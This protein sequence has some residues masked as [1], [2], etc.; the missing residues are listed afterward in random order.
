MFDVFDYEVD[1]R[2]MCMLLCFRICLAMLTAM[3]VFMMCFRMYLTEVWQQ[4][5][6]VYAVCFR[7]CLRF[8]A[9]RMCLCC[10]FQN[11]F[12]NEADSNL[13]VSECV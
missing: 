3:H 4:H 13:C 11:V 8:A 5:T 6:C 12:D 2:D 9:T 1:S 10:V 7:M